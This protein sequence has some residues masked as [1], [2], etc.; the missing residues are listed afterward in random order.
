MEATHQ[1]HKPFGTQITFSQLSL[2]NKGEIVFS[3]TLKSILDFAK[4]SYLAM[5]MI[6]VLFA[7][8]ELKNI[9]NIDILPGIDTPIDNA[10]FSGKEQVMNNVL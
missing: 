6:L 3:K 9:Y 2:K 1:L 5:V 4:Y 10:Y 7:I 8:V